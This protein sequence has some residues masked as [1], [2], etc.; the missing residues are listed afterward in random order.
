MIRCLLVDDEHFALVLL[1]EYIRQTPG[2]TVAGVCRSPIRAVEFLQSEPVD[3][4]FLDIQMP[5]LSGMGL[6]K[7][8]SRK[9]IT[10]F[11][12]AYPQHAHE[13]FDLDAVDYLLKPFSFER[14]TQA[15]EK[16]REK[17][18]F[19]KGETSASLR[20]EGNIS[21]RADRKWINIPL[22]EI[23]YIEGWKEYVRIYTDTGRIITLESMS[24]LEAQLPEAFFARAHK[25]FIVARHQVRSME[26]AILELVNGAQ[27]QVS[28]ARK[29]EM[30]EW[31]FSR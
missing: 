27:V 17:L 3:L 4:L 13:A 29:K 23:Q 12:T 6:L 18:T 16:A 30:T 1:E 22:A 2:L 31:L 15:I 8:I 28:R 20:P 14:F 21:V 11:T 24:N 19:R 25:S 7:S 26:G 10:I 5:V 9:P